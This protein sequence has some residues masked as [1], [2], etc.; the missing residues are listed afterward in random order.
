MKNICLFA[1]A[2]IMTTRLMAQ[3]SIGGMPYPF[4]QAEEHT[5]HK[6]QR[7]GTAGDF[8][9]S[10]HVDTLQHEND[11]TLKA[12]YVGNTCDTNITPENSGTLFR[13]DDKIIWRVGVL[14]SGAASIGLVFTEFN[15]PTNAKLFLYNPR[16]TTVLG[17][18]TDIN[19]NNHGILPIQPIAS[20]TVIVEYIEPATKDGTAIQGRLKIGM[21]SHNFYNIGELRRANPGGG[22]LCTPHV[23][24]AAYENPFKN[25]SCALFVASKSGRAW[26]G[27]GQLINNPDKKPYVISAAHLFNTADDMTQT[28]FYFQ[29]QT[30]RQDTLVIGSMELTIAGSSTLAYET[31]LDLAL[32]QLNQTPPKDYRAYLAGWDASEN[33]QGPL[34]CIQHPNG[35][36]AKVSFSNNNPIKSYITFDKDKFP[37]QSFWKVSKWNKGTTQAGSSGSALLNPDNRIIGTLTGG[38]STCASPI[39]DY[40][41]QI[42]EQFSHYSEPD[43]NLKSWLDPHS[44]GIT[45]M[46][47][48]YLYPSNDACERT[49]NIADGDILGANRLNIG[50]G[51]QAGSNSLGYKEYAEKFEFDNEMSIHGVYVMTVKGTYNASRPV[52]LNIYTKNE[53]GGYELAKQTLVKP[54]DY[55]FTYSGE[56]KSSVFTNWKTREIY[57]RLPEAV[58]VGT[59]CLVAIQKDEFS[60][61]DSISVY[62]T[63]NRIGTEGNTAFF[64]SSGTWK[65][66]TQ[67]PE[68]AMPASLWIEPVVS[69]TSS[70]SVEENAETQDRTIFN[71]YSNTAYRYVTVAAA[72]IEQVSF[73]LTDISGRT[74]KRGVMNLSHG[75]DQLQI[76]GTCGLYLLQLTYGSYSETHKIIKR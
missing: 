68:Q 35:D 9:I 70:T 44:T 73:L 40:F 63:L 37:F 38:S 41:S 59:E 19:N 23:N 72:E 18:F 61:T 67:Y 33:Q 42:S 28:V 50:D 16:Q 69:L 5:P 60:S 36:F 25:S 52:Y 54:T 46:D 17:A 62:Q 12:M 11:T 1:I 24:Q 65:P 30:P 14:S 7:L 49:S 27:S 47:G 15:I 29:Y 10:L 71:V 64:K 22:N 45:Y 56:T 2:L 53:G 26:F 55:S 51:Y 43:K 3:I 4:C 48:E 13:K 76:P 20:D 75:A 21:A 6:F 57:V 8:Y 31:T 32:M 58:N 39:N 34:T 74:I 66:F